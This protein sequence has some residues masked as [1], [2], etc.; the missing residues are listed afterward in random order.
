RPM[1]GKATKVE[2]S[3]SDRRYGLDVKA[4]YVFPSFATVTGFFSTS[5]FLSIRI[6]NWTKILK[7]L[8]FRKSRP[9]DLQ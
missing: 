5:I 7:I 9:D 8:E 3:R 6:A 2:R 4:R 1:L